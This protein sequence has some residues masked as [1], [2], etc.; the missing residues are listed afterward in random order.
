[1]GGK[2]RG[3]KGGL[4]WETCSREMQNC[5]LPVAWTAVHQIIALRCPSAYSK[6]TPG[7]RW[8]PTAPAN[9]ATSLYRATM[10]KEAI[11]Q[12]CKQSFGNGTI[13]WQTTRGRVNEN[14]HRT[15]QVWLSRAGLT[16]CMQQLSGHEGSTTGKANKARDLNRQAEIQLS[17]HSGSSYPST[18][19]GCIR[20]GNHA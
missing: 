17:S 16:D 13:C 7:V 19:Y 3:L 11:W 12:Q 1:M 10:G 2:P 14:C 5:K 20:V 18:S 15:A 9:H 8:R 4:N 6:C